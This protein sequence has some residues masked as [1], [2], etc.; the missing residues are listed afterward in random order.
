[1]RLA[2]VMLASCSSHLAL[3]GSPP[4][5]API[6]SDGGGTVL[7][8][9]ALGET[10]SATLVNGW[11]VWAIDHLDGTV[12][13]VSGVGP[14]RDRSAATLFAPQAALVRWFP[15]V[16]RFLAGDVIYDDRGHVLGYARRWCR[17]NC[18]QVAE[19]APMERDLDTFSATLASDQVLVGARQRSPAPEP[20]WHD[21]DLREHE[22]FDL[23]TTNDVMPPVEALER[24]RDRPTGSYALVSAAIVRSTI[25]PPKLCSDGTCE[26]ALGLD[27][28][29]INAPA[30][31]TARGTLL[32]RRDPRGLQ[33]IASYAPHR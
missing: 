21:F 9:P 17:D 13:V 16:R 31:Y 33:I 8:I 30:T 2:I 23:V 5:I 27:P 20:Q 11:P 18:P 12:T 25:E 29:A 28:I 6:V 19:P 1:M 15:P 22:A 24:V 7:A 14:P 10:Q 32:V 26:R 3:R 4:V